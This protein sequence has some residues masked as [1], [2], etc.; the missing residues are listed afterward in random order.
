MLDKNIFNMCLEQLDTLL[1]L[2]SVKIINNQTQ[3]PGERCDCLISINTETGNQNFCIQVKRTLKRPISTH[4]ISVKDNTKLPLLLMSEYVN[5]SIAKDFKKH[6]IYFIDSYGNAYIH[7]PGRI[8]I[9]VQD[10][11]PEFKKIQSTSLFQPKGLQLLYLLLTNERFLNETVRTLAKNAGIS[12]DRA[13]T[14]MKELKDKGFI[15]EI[16]RRQFQFMNKKDLLDQ[17][18]VNYKDRLRPRL[19]LGSF[20]AP[21]SIWE[22]ILEKVKSIFSQ[23]E[24]KFAISGSFA[25]NILTHYYRGNSLELFIEPEILT[26]LKKDLKLLVTDKPNVNLF[27]LFSPHVIYNSIDMPYTVAH[28]LLIYSELVQHGGD[29]EMQT[30]KLVYQRFLEQDFDGA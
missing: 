24:Y 28:P 14:A 8:Y 9:N 10:N 16:A 12:K 1:P 2:K 3:Q 25:A 20:I 21:P 17:W 11:K 26:V 19:V 7:I 13:A 18:L 22:D 5:P 23:T 6:N 27:M 30:A 29:R 15:R 4:L